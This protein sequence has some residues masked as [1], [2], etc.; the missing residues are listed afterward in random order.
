MEIQFNGHHWWQCSQRVTL[1]SWGQGFTRQK[2][3]NAKVAESA[4]TADTTVIILF[5]AVTHHHNRHNRHTG[6]KDDDDP[7]VQLCVLIRPM[8]QDLNRPIGRG[9][10]QQQ[11]VAPC[12]K[13]FLWKGLFTHS[14]SEWLI[15]MEWGEAI[16]Q[17]CK[18]FDFTA[19]FSSKEEIVEQANFANQV[20]SYQISLGLTFKGELRR[21]AAKAGVNVIVQ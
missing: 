16:N 5:I 20:H 12:R 3:D 14:K 2:K 1:L 11:L 9:Q 6:L 4:I 13:R 17:S 7:P 18:K 8:T 19:R 10:L 15:I 21:L